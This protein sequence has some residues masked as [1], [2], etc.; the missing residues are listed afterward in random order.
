MT[1]VYVIYDFFYAELP[2]PSVIRSFSQTESQ[3]TKMD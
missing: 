2:F 3:M 1:A